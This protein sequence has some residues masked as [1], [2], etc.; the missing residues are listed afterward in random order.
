[1]FSTRSDT[2]QAVQPQNMARGLKF[3]NE[4]VEGLYYLCSENEGAAQLR[5]NLAAVLPLCF[6]VLPLCFRIC[7]KQAF[8][9]S[10]DPAHI[11]HE[12]LCHYVEI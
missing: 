8:S 12:I 3:R 11:F 10:H 2:N 9:N 7:K 6:R 5:R 1:M 4:E